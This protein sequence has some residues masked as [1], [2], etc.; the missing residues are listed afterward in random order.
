MNIAE[1]FK[2]YS[3]LDKNELRERYDECIN[4]DYD[5]GIPWSWFFDMKNQGLI[6]QET[7]EYATRAKK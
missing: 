1:K 3:T 5:H 7:F 4:G 2:Y 6:N